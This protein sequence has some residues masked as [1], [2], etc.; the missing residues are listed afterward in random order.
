V[1]FHHVSRIVRKAQR[2]DVGSIWELPV[3]TVSV[4]VELSIEWIVWVLAIMPGGNRCWENRP[5]QPPAAPTT[6]RPKHNGRFD[7]STGQ[8]QGAPVIED[9]HT[10]PVRVDDSG[11]VHIGIG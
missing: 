5:A 1:S 8:A 3:R 9:L 10:Y 7:Y 2:L 11:T 4:E 6:T